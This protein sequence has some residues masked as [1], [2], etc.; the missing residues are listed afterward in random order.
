[1][2]TLL[3]TASVTAYSYAYTS[4]TVGFVLPLLRVRGKQDW[5]VQ[6]V[7][8]HSD[9]VSA[10]RVFDLELVELK[11]IP[12]PVAINIDELQIYVFVDNTS[13]RVGNKFAL[14]PALRAFASEHPNEPATAL[15]IYQIVGSLQ[16][17]RAA[18][19]QMRHTLQ[20][21]LGRHNAQAFYASALR[22]VF[23]IKLTQA[24]SLGTDSARRAELKAQSRLYIDENGYLHVDNVG[25]RDE[26]ES[27]Q[28]QLIVS[29][30]SAEFEQPDT[31]LATAYP[32]SET[33]RQVRLRDIRWKVR[34]EER[35]ALLLGE[36]L[37]N[38]RFGLELLNSYEPRA[39]FEQ[40]AVERLKRE[41]GHAMFSETSDEM[42][43]AKLVEPLFTTS[44]PFNRGHLLEYLSQHPG[45]FRHVN[46]AIQ[47]KLS[48]T[49]SIYVHE[50]AGRI[51]Q[52]LNHTFS[53][54]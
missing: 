49:Q 45:K 43:V 54:T 5:Y 40:S 41:L 32:T 36:I 13:I 44:F 29:E 10:F 46:E 34:Q 30:L 20:E 47:K 28:L 48:E 19:L 16:E 2:S 15:Q 1:M 21:Q 37:E 12:Q 31:L 53:K 50:H 4:A 11:E 24:W 23:W 14:E 22:S 18:R 9:R 17:R 27:E 38:R 26:H 3:K 52:N 35:I 42:A 33:R 8:E 39:K 25:S 7:D 6:Q 51:G